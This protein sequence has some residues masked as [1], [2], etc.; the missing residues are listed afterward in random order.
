MSDENIDPLDRLIMNTDEI[1]GE[2]RKMLAE[3]LEPHVKI[4]PDTGKVY[5]VPYPPKLNTKQHVLVFLLAKLALSQKNEALDP[6]YTAKGV[7]EGT[8]LPGGT[9]RPKLSELFNERI[10]S[11]GDNGY[12]VEGVNL[13]KARSILEDTLMNDS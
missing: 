7:E 11:K 10:I 2:S 4:D 1:D 13:Y 3:M 8:G 9:V 6:V 5:F 12:F